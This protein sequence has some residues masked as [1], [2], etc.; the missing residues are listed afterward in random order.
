MIPWLLPSKSATN[1]GM[2]CHAWMVA[3]PLGNK[4]HVASL[5]SQSVTKRQRDICVPYKNEY[6][7][8][9]AHPGT[10]EYLMKLGP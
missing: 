5:G 1:G 10:K 7:L 2:E 9:P 4:K 6:F 8:N 3:I